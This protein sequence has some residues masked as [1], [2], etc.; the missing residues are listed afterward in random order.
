MV[1]PVLQ[2]HEA[3]SLAEWYPQSITTPFICKQI[4]SQSKLCSNLEWSYLWLYQEGSILYPF[5]HKFSYLYWTMLIFH[6]GRVWRCNANHRQLLSGQGKPW[7]TKRSAS[8]IQETHVA[9]FSQ[10]ENNL[11]KDASIFFAGIG[12]GKEKKAHARSLG[13]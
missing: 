1:G 7:G 6:P 8:W 2:G 9:A 4:W 12:T 13:L 5:V 10:G 3:Y 11:Y